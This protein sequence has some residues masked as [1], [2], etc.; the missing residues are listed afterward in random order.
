MIINTLTK[1]IISTAAFRLLFNNISFPSTIA[2]ADIVDYGYAILHRSDLPVYNSNTHKCIAAPTA[3]VDGK[4]QLQYAVI[5]LTPIELLVLS[6]NQ[7]EIKKMLRAEQTEAIKVTT[8]A[9]NTFDGDEV[10][11][12]RMARA[13]IALSTGIVP[14]VTWVLSDNTV[15][16]ATAAELT[17]ALVLSGAAQS[18]LWVI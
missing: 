15:I 12:G 4:W 10:S 5:A 16:Q 9:G 18:A 13:V 17:E 14:S 7:R 11:Q 2:E 6:D 8:S 1:E 3:M